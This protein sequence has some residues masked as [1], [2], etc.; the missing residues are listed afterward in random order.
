MVKF[1]SPSTPQ[2]SSKGASPPPSAVNGVHI[3]AIIRRKLSPVWAAPALPSTEAVSSGLHA[4]PVLAPTHL[5]MASLPCCPV[6]GDGGCVRHVSV[7]PS[8]A[9]TNRHVSQ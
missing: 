7:S 9:P 6:A 5:I 1:S 8:L 3:P 2:G 4:I